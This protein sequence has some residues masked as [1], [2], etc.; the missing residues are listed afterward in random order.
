M[1]FFSSPTFL[2]ALAAAAFPGRSCSQELVSC[3]RKVFRLLVVDGAP[4]TDWFCLDYLE[5]LEPGSDESIRHRVRRLPRVV[6][7]S[8]E[9]D[10][11]RVLQER[12]G[13]FPANGEIAPYIS[14]ERFASWE[15]YE[16]HLGLKT[17]RKKKRRASL[18]NAL[19]QRLGPIEFLVNDQNWLALNY[20]L[21]WKERQFPGLLSHE[22]NRKLYEILFENKAL[23]AYSLKAGDEYIAVELNVE[24]DGRFMAWMSAFNPAH[25]YGSPGKLL[26]ESILKHRFLAG[27]REYDCMRGDEPYKLRYATDIRVLEP[28]EESPP[29][30][31]QNLWARLHRR[32][33]AAWLPLS[34]SSHILY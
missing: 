4:I 5:A 6:T 20:C 7:A 21:T 16:N 12:E 18:R 2:D 27:D 32:V 30:R 22:A 13:S 19:S 33:K 10:A 29:P 1:G 15:D 34:K 8:M 31:W 26:F 11:W 23:K 28:V 24:H 25:A 17:A 14:W 9:I 3:Q